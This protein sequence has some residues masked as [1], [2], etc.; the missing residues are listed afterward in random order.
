LPKLVRLLCLLI[1]LPALLPGPGLSVA[2]AA[3]R[4]PKIETPGYRHLFFRGEDPA[5]PLA[6][7]WSQTV[8]LDEEET[9]ER[10][11]RFTLTLARE[12]G[13]GGGIPVAVVDEAMGDFCESD[14]GEIRVEEQTSGF[15]HLG[16]PVLCR[17]LPPPEQRA[18][19]NLVEGHVV[20]HRPKLARLDHRYAMLLPVQ[21]LAARATTLDFAV[22]HGAGQRPAVRAHGWSIEMNVKELGLG[23]YRTFF[24]LESVERLPQRSG[25]G[26]LSGRVPSVAITSGETWDALALDH[27]A[28]FDAAAR[29]KGDAIPLAGRVLAQPD[30]LSAVLEAVRLALDT[31][32]FDASG[33]RGGG[34]QLPRRAGETAGAGS[35]TAADRAALLVAML[36]A[37][38]VRA[39][40][41]LAS[42]SAHR[43]TPGDAPLALLN[44]TLVFLPD[45][46]LEEG[47]GPLFIDPSRGSAWLGAL[48]ESLIGRDALMLG[49]RGARW[50]RLPATPPRQSWTLNARQGADMGFELQL[51]GVL[52]GA[53]AARVREWAAAGRPVDQLPAED[54][55]WLGSVWRDGLEIGI[56]EEAGGRLAVSASGNLPVDVALT[57]QHLPVPRLPRSAVADR[58]GASWPYA[59][60]TVP[61]EV[62]LLE[63]WTFRSRHSGGAPPEGQK[64]TPFWQVDSLGSWSGPL[65]SRRTR[66]RFEGAVLAPAAAMEVERFVD[67]CARV[68]GGVTAP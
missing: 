47:G 14:V 50:L 44:Q 65:F 66:V 36:R 6:E 30:V 22:E 26:T 21:P 4:G 15:G 27:K 25:V 2:E 29:A 45:V 68:L 24:Q 60:D 56:E 34:W 7:T 3:R 5:V 63:S 55:A 28:F 1:V 35:G 33:G 16:L 52:D 11:V 51:N 17:W 10:H 41:V 42:R 58:S 13:P 20:V 39:E 43:V 9:I 32:T 67:Y 18:A 54:L 23:R 53:P 61:L 19:G 57:D 59:R 62:D 49:D 37:S 64:L 12:L 8:V 46:H 40:I 38:E 31:V 48:D